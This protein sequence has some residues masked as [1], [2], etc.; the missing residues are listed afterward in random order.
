MKKR[1]N[2]TMSEAVGKWPTEEE[3][4]IQIPKFGKA[5]VKGGQDITTPERILLDL[6]AEIE[7]NIFEFRSV[8]APRYELENY[9]A[10]RSTGR[11]DTLNALY[12]YLTGAGPQEATAL[13]VEVL[14]TRDLP[15]QRRPLAEWAAGPGR[16][17]KD[18]P[19]DTGGVDLARRTHSNT[20][21]ALIERLR[22]LTA[23]EWT[24]TT[25]QEATMDKAAETAATQLLEELAGELCDPGESLTVGRGWAHIINSEGDEVQALG[26]DELP[27]GYTG[28]VDR[29]L[30]ARGS[31]FSINPRKKKS[32]K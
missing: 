27:D 6:R 22:E 26:P 31:V 16:T 1:H 7:T 4:Y 11:I 12:S 18:N 3:Y 28:A 21:D 13:V 10:Q 9:Q 20:E 8:A 29:L 5:K 24:P 23:G 19:W 14:R 2:D 15:E 32:T 25:V 30:E 17:A